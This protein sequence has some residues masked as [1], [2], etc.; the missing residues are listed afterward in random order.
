ML[1]HSAHP[2]AFVAHG[3]SLSGVLHLPDPAPWAVIVGCHGLMADKN[4][5]KQIALAR[6]CSAAGMAYFR[7]D[8]RGCGQSEGVF[9]SDTTLE[10][11]KSDLVAAVQAIHNR[12]GQ[13][14]PVGLFGSSLGGTVCLTAATDI[15]PFATVTLAAPVHSR[16]IRLPEDSP[17]SLKNEIFRRRLTFDITA[18]IASIGH[19]LVIHGSRDATVPVEN[20]HTIYRLA[21]DPKKKLILRGGDHRVSSAAHQK[22]FLQAA[23]QWFADCRG[24]LPKK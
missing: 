20:A 1:T 9:E 22:K 12:L 18:A 19:I 23:V 7:F 16:S 17:Q 11:R 14:I 24:A 3:L 8:H 15:S 13:T 6:G 4:S 10:N 21:C 2:V 5:P